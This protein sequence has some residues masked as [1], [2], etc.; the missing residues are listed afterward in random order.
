MRTARLSLWSAGA[1]LG[2]AGEWALYGW[3]DPGKWVPDLAAGWSMIACGQVAWSRRPESRSGVLMAATGFT[4]FAGNFATVDAAWL[5]WLS[6]HALFLYRGPLVH[7]VLTY[8]RGRLAGRLD[9][10]G[11]GGGYA[12]AVV[13][14]VWQSESATIVLAGCLVVI[15]G[16]SY[17]HATGRERREQRAGWQAA[18]FVAL[19]L[20]GAAAVRLAVPTQRAQDATL[21]ASELALCVLAVAL[22]TGLL[23]APWARANLTDLVVELGE[24]QSGTLRDALARTLHDPTLQLGYWAPDAGAYVD[25]AGRPLELPHTHGS[26]ALTRIDRDG[27]AVAALVHDPAVLDDPRLLA[28]VSAASRLAASNARLQAEV[29]A[30]LVELE[31]SRRRLLRSADAERQRLERRLRNG[32]ERR[33]LRLKRTLAQARRDTRAGPEVVERIDGAEA[34]L[35]RTLAE[36]RELA[37][38]LHPRAVTEHGLAG[39]LVAVAEQS[40]VPVELSLSADQ[41]PKDIETAVYF[42]C[43]EALANV[44]K[45]SSASR[46][47][48]DVTVGGGMTRVAI[49]DDGVGGADPASGSGL[50]G[51]ADRVETLGGSL[52]VESPP[53]SGTRVVAE[54]PLDDLR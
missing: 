45:Y 52:L 7:L 54:F 32:A 42:V 29:R 27:R 31:A 15:A 14:P 22:L 10:A 12:A 6:A 40:P 11:V 44:A 18:T 30:Q 5:A 9:R 17:L 49:A 4:W 26:R 21:L 35:G 41:L 43:S 39:A 25:D 51:L 3:A 33:L 48:V 38:G 19:I 24:I 16:H 20:A 46:V 13:T 1:V 50:R 47:S 2:L 53:G 36:L 37:Q 23:E 28:A 34:Q 8:P